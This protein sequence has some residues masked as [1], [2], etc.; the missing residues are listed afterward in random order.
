M[1]KAGLRWTLP[2]LR[3]SGSEN[4]GNVGGKDE[5]ITKLLSS[6]LSDRNEVT[7][8]RVVQVELN[9]NTPSV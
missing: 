9:F 5:E 6:L 3:T 1:T 8:C 4:A 2:S 7:L